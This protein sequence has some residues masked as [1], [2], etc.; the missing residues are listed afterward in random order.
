MREIGYRAF[1]LLVYPQ[2]CT[3]CITCEL[4][5]S[6]RFYK[7][8]QPTAAAIVID[9]SESGNLGS[10]ITFTEQ[11]DL[12]GICGRYCPYGALVWQRKERVAN[13]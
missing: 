10:K 8:S 4:R 1:E 2:K 5:C 9:R 11:C 12:C 6:W 13:A 3:G 7:Q